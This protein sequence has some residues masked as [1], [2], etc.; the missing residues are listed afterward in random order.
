MGTITLNISDETEHT[1]RSTVE[2]R[3]GTGKGVLGKAAEE[4]LLKWA[5]E[6]EQENAKQKLIELMNKAHK[7]SIPM[8]KKRS[9]IY[10]HRINRF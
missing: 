3:V 2:K 5:E 1:S 9:E 7:L 10:E 6:Y 8:Y 4:A